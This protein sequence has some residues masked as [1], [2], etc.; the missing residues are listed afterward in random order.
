M[1]IRALEQQYGGRF[2]SAA[3]SSGIE[4]EILNS[5]SGSRGIVFGSRGPNQVGHVF[6][7][8]NQNGVVRFLDGQSGKPATFGGYQSL[9]LL[10]TN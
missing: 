8:V 1:S 6:N 3:T 5:G 9:H 4:Q 7:V 2:G 10:K